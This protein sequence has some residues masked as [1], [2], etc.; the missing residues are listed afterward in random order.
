MHIPGID[1]YSAQQLASGVLGF[2]IQGS[3]EG[4]T[5]GEWR[6]N[7]VVKFTK[8]CA[9]RSKKQICQIG[10]RLACSWSLWVY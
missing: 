10:M 1:V 3:G 7:M 5:V 9:T 6:E 2:Q 4:E 8:G